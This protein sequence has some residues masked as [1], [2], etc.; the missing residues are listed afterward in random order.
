MEISDNMQIIIDFLNDFS[1]LI[2]AI[3]AIVV[4]IIKSY[5]NTKKE[6]DTLPKKIKKQTSIDV[7]ITARME[8]IKE[9]LNA[10]RVQI[11]DFH[12]GGHYANGRSALKTSC[13]YEVVRTGISPKQMYLQA[14]PLSCISKFTR[15][16][17]DNEFLEIKNLEDIKD[18]MPS[19]YQ[20]KKEMKINSFYDIILNNK[21][22]EPIGFLAIQFV[23]N[24]Y[25]IS[26]DKDKREILKLKFFIEEQLE[27]II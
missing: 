4:A 17:L 24:N 7:L 8:E 21:E 26:S 23:K 3:S 15:K 2:L 20:L 12:N 10:D 1:L 11:Y 9:L 14:I 27:K 25:N 18:D 19:T 6:L 16:L 22:G 13:T 5:K